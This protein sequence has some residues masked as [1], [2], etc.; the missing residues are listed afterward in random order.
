MNVL[1]ICSHG[2]LCDKIKY[3]L[4]KIY[5][6]DENYYDISDNILDARSKLH[7]HVDIV[8]ADYNLE[9]YGPGAG[10]MVLQ[11]LHDDIRFNMS[12][13]KTIL[14]YLKN[15]ILTIDEFQRKHGHWFRILN[16]SFNIED[17]NIAIR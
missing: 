9:G 11:A 14:L 10:M 3:A 12:G 13:V 4:D 5:K 16:K 1:I 8:I 15:D 6:N 17:M 2:I 7:N